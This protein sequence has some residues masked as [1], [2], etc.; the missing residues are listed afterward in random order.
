[1]KI[2]ALRRAPT[3]ED[4]FDLR[5]LRQVER[6]HPELFRDLPKVPDLLRLSTP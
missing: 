6:E 4:M 1:M 5:A 2:G 3:F